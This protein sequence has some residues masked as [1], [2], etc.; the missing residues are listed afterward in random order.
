MGVLTVGG[1]GG[2][3]KKS[4]KRGFKASERGEGKLRNPYLKIM[5]NIVLSMPVTKLIQLFST[6]IYH[7][8]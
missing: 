2:E 1:G 7:R 6:R 3:V 8:N 5:Y 4:D